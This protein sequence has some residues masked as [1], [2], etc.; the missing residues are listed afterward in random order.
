MLYLF[1]NA[2]LIEACKTPETESVGYIDDVSILA[3]G[4]SATRNCKILKAMHRKAQ[5]WARK[6]GSQ[7]SPTKYELVHFTRDPKTSTTHPLR[8]PHAT[9]MATASCRYL[10][11]QLDSRLRWDYHREKIAAAATKRLSALSALASSTWG[12]GMLNLRQVYRAMIVPQMLYGCSAWHVPGKGSTSGGSAMLNTI[13]KVQRRAAQII[14]GGFRTTAGA[15]VD[16]E[17]HLL[18]VQ[19]QLEQ[20]AL[21]AIMRIRTSP[22]HADMAV[23]VGDGAAPRLTCRGDDN[24]SPLDRLSSILEQKYDVRLD[25]L[26]KRQPHV[27]P[28]WWVPPF[29]SPDRSKERSSLTVRRNAH[30]SPPGPPIALVNTVGA[31]KLIDNGVTPKPSG[32]IVK[33][34]DYNVKLTVKD[35]GGKTLSGLKVVPLKDDE[36]NW[37]GKNKA[38]TGS[39]SGS[40]NSTSDSGKSGKSDDK[41][42]AADLTRPMMWAVT[43]SLAV[44]MMFA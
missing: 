40:D 44:M 5:E 31:Q 15:A 23:S 19:Q 4:P 16:I 21:E 35:K 22:L 7:F 6:H 42:D 37:A 20:T 43:L 32:K 34:S 30:N 3:I 8:L 39:A 33:I 26:E 28:P 12:T 18:P 13:K 9:I 38:E 36:F 1:Y 41:K 25:R 2:D 10:G 17:A 24:R 27:V 14:T 11:I 29:S